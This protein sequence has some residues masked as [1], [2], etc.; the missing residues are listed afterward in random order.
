MIA[1]TEEE[2]TALEAEQKQIEQTLAS[3]ENQTPEMFRKYETV[4]HHIE[5]KLYEWQ[6]LN[7]S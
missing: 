4:K 2:I 7:E 5:Q 6:L 1:Q 3:P